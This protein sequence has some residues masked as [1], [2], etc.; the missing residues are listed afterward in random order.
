[1]ITL[2]SI[3]PMVFIVF[4]VF[5]TLLVIGLTVIIFVFWDMHANG[6]A[7]YPILTWYGLS[8]LGM[9]VNLM[10]YGYLR[11]EILIF[12]YMS[13]SNGSIVCFCRN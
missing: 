1:M 4:G 12:L 5:C 10:G 3:L 6:S 7:N 13:R 11:H 2:L 9:W 8:I